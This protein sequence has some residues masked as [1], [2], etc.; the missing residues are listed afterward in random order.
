MQS[1]GMRTLFS[2]QYATRS[3]ALAGATVLNA[4]NVLITTTILPS[5]VRDIGGQ[6]LYAWNTTLY[7]I[8]SIVGAALAPRTLVRL[9]PKGAFRIA[10][11]AFFL[12]ALV[13]TLAPSMVVLV[14]GRTVQGF[15]GGYL[16]T[17]TYAII[18][19]AY[20][21]TLWPRAFALNSA[22]WGIATVL[23]PAVGGIFAELGVWRLA[24]GVMMILSVALGLLFERVLRGMPRPEIAIT[25]V[26]VVQLMVLCL[27]V[28]AVS[29]GSLADNAVSNALGIVIAAGLIVVLAR[30]E[31]RNRNKLMPTGT[32]EL[33]SPL[34][35]IFAAMVLLMIAVSAD[36]FTPYFLQNLH[37]MSPLLAGYVVA[38][39]SVGW[40]LGSVM[41]AGAT[42]ARARAVM[43]GSPLLMTGGLVVVTLLMPAGGNGAV[44]LGAIA[45]G[46]LLLGLGMGSTFPH[47]LS[48]SMSLALHHE[49]ALAATSMTTVQL[50]GSAFGAAFG[51]VITNLNH[52]S[53][54]AGG[55][56]VRAATW[57]FSVFCLFPLA[58]FVC[59]VVVLRR[60]APSEPA[61][62]TATSQAD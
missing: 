18:R 33:G 4:V 27:A 60:H 15:G 55:G 6:N 24:F 17:L 36:V 31:R 10:V 42:G 57:Y 47:L 20:P 28:L 19:E 35:P 1:P 26:P 62:A 54:L 44:H 46:L 51:G 56:T 9:G 5:V 53:D 45:L 12:G 49:Q 34:G 32:L 39:M 41:M 30:V 3:V 13:C 29:A 58:A 50:V 21:E 11:V 8:A 52:Y 16:G 25:R 14:L 37:G 40:T 48:R 38:V 23:G 43:L 61:P 2:H 59:T 22:M 7:V